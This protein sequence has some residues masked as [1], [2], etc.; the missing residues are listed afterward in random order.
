MEHRRIAVCVQF[1]VRQEECHRFIVLERVFKSL[2]FI[3]IQVF[4]LI[5]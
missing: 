2:K 3:F 1:L 5:S 4:H